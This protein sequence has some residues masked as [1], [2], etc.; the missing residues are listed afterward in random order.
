MRVRIKFCGITRPADAVDAARA[1]AD[2]I[3]MV[4]APESPR[5]V[6]PATAAAIAAALPPFVSRVGVFVNPAAED[7]RA[8]MHAGRLDLLQFHGEETADFCT[9]FGIP[10]LR[11]VRVRE[12]GD[13]LRADREHPAACAL[14]LDAWVAGSHGGTGTTFAWDVVPN[15]LAHPLVLAGGL[16]AANVARAIGVVRPYAVDVSGGI[17]IQPGIKDAG[18]M[19]RFAAA[20]RSAEN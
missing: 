19:R 9:A 10:Y 15:A 8:A 11:A 5:R 7:V 3:G 6:A 12:A 20:V 1:G 13:I 14:L 17:E 2:A 18:R 4:F 16:D